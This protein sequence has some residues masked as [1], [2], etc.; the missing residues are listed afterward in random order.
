MSREAKIL[1]AILVLVVGGMIGL[2]AVANKGTSTPSPTA[3]GDKTKIVRD[4]THKEGTGTLQLVEFG[5]FQCP[6][7]GAA[8]PNI[9]KLV[10][11]YEGKVTFSFRNFPLTTIHQNAQAGAQAAEAAAEQ[12]KYWEMHDKLYETQNDW[13]ELSD[14]TDKFASYAKD[15]GLDADKFKKA[16]T[17][18]SVAKIIAQDAADGD[19]LGVQSTPTFFI[20]GVQHQGSFDYNT[21]KKAIDDALAKQQ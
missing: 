5:D 18:E 15:L 12:D 16:L 4:T 2:F 1:T 6:A 11:E 20:E 8:H 3:V 7:C 10:Q 21:L 9:K 19:A 14:P 17:G 13:S